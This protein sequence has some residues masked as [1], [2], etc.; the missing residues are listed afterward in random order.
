MN[1]KELTLAAEFLEQHSDDLSDNGC[2]DWKYPDDWTE[3]EKIDFCREYYEWRRGEEYFNRSD[4]SLPDFAV[5]EFLA[6]KLIL[7]AEHEKK[8]NEVDYQ[9]CDHD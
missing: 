8:M 5:A 3:Q 4:L 1:H 7:Q 6:H 2:N 9:S